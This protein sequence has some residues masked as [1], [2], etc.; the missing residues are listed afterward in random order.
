MSALTIRSVAPPWYRQ[1][2]PW[3]LVA[4]P[5]IVVLASLVTLWLAISSDDGV[6]ADDY[7][8]RG[9]LINREIDRTARAEAMH[10][11]AVL[12]VAPDGAALLALDGFA[13]ASAAPAAVRVHIAH[14]TR[15]GLDRHVTLTRG[16]AGVYVGVISPRPMGRWH[17][18]IETDQWK[19]P[20]AAVVDGLA[21][22]RI[23]ESRS[24]N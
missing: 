24:D 5:A 13:D 7:Y 20:D 11:G 3:L 14:P 21:E 22:V 16:P 10:L 19:L 23:G 17:V 6:I 4:G 12:R 9:L 8:K 15:A 2:W 1:R 18:A